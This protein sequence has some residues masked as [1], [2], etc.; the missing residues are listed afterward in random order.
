MSD[1]EVAQERPLTALEQKWK[2]EEEAKQ[3]REPEL[4]DLYKGDNALDPSSMPEKVLD[5]IPRPTGWRITVLPYRGPDK[6][7][8]GIALADQTRQLNQLT[9]TCG[10]VLKMGDLA[11]KDEVKFP[12]GPWCKEGD[13]V[14]FARY[15]GSRMNIDGGEIRILNDDEI[16]GIVQDP[17]DIL[18]M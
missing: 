8:G 17:E 4:Q 6:S 3:N 14:I 12:N 11:Y 9:T 2:E 5:R 18:H 1:A 7:K 16:L 10:Y 13:W 15:G